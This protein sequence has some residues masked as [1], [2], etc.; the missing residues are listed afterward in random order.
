[1]PKPLG[2]AFTLVELLLTLAILAFCLTG[3]LSTYINMFMLSD[4]ARDLTLATNSAQEKM[5]EIKRTRFDSLSAL[6]GTTFDL[7]NFPVTDSEGAIEVTNTAYPDLKRVRITAAFKSRLKIIGEDK[8]LNGILD[9]GE[10]LNGNGRLDSTLEL[11]T[12]IAR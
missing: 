12:L 4:L 9:S 11:V 1:M 6:N 5:E 3:I 10:D 8:N 7:A 2:K